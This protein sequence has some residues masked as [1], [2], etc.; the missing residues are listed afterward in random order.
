[1]NREAQFFSGGSNYRMGNSS[2]NGRDTRL[3][4]QMFNSIFHSVNGRETGMYNA[5]TLT[6]DTARNTGLN[7]QQQ[8]NGI[9]A[10][11]EAAKTMYELTNEHKYYM[12]QRDFKQIANDNFNVDN[13]QWRMS[14]RN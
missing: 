12:M 13:R 4:N 2:T 7:R 8:V 11:F 14:N 5:Q 10:R 3:D 6:R 1:M 9:G